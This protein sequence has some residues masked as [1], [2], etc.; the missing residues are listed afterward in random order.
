MK[1]LFSTL[2]LFFSAQAF[3]MSA[4]KCQSTDWFAVGRDSG[5]KGL[6]SDKIMKTQVDCQKKGVE[7]SL[8]QYQKGWQMGI[9]QYCSSDNA[10]N[11]G[12]KKK[13]PSKFCPI[14][15]RSDFDQFYAWGKEAFGL[16]KDIKSKESKLKSKVSKLKSVNQKR[17]GLEKEIKT[18]EEQ[19]KA[20][21]QKVDSIESQMK[22]KRSII[23]K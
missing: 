5:V 6:P 13:T 19:T 9:G 22:K 7:I 12:F 3:S 11:L 8:D 18:L 23:K 2:V 4:D 20:L 16:E 15:L 21:N 17:E 1:V 10:F 14:D